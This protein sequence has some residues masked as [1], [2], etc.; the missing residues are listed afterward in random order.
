M[1]EHFS[2]IIP[3]EIHQNLIQHLIRK[4][5]QED[6]CF[7]L[8]YPSAGSKRNTGIVKDIILPQDGER[9]VHGNVGFL[10]RYFE[11]VIALASQQNAGIAFIHSHPWA[12][13]QG[14]SHDDKIAETR[15]SPAVMA[16][17]GYPLLG[18]TL[19]T[20]GAWS[21]RFWNKDHSAKRSYIRNWCESVRVIGEGLSITFNENLLKPA[22]NHSTQLRTISAWG[23]KAQSDISRLK[24]GIVGLGSVGSMVAEILSRTG[25]SNFTLIDFDKVE[26][27][28][29]DRLTNVF[30]SDLGRPKVEAIR[31]GI[32]RSATSPNLNINICESSV[33]EREGY[34]EALNCDVLFSCV[35]RPWPRQILN[36]ISYCHYIPVIDG[37]I[38]VRT[39]KENSKIIGSDWKVQTVGYKR[40]C[41]E[42]LGQYKTSDAML[43]RDGY[44][45]DPSYIEGLENKDRFLGNENVF[46]FSSHL[47]SMEVLQMLSLV[48]SPS[49]I[50]NI[51][52]Q[53]YHFVPGILDNEHTKTC[54]RNCF[55]QAIV[56]QGD[57]SDV[58][59]W[60]RHVKLHN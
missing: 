23:E 9:L 26:E 8:Y 3:E 59:L 41:L 37:G 31:D 40:P 24:I 1:I 52:Q 22:F 15:M 58:E 36:Y 39:N 46:V 7:A 27:K 57:H 20:D 51:G 47:A 33:C 14:M 21:A 55:F 49:G 4:D 29:L 17:T 30:R 16:S 25:V 18:L 45:D 6:L 38:K 12:G 42:C 34:Q 56:G 44:L 53:I 54:H 43:E 10:P 28:N 19:G 13:W 50:S 35:D 2:V 32:L 5:G 60:G 48:I 11:R